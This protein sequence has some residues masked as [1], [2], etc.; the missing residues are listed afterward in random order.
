M[1]WLGTAFAFSQAQWGVALLVEPKYLA[2][3]W[4]SPTLGSK[5]EARQ[6]DN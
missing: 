3:R 2:F 1:Y 4:T 6:C 5:K